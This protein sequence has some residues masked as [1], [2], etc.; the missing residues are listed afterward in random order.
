[1]RNEPNKGWTEDGIVRLWPPTFFT[2]EYIVAWLSLY[3]NVDLVIRPFGFPYESISRFREKN[4]G[5]HLAVNNSTVLRR[6][7]WLHRCYSSVRQ[8]V[9]PVQ[10]V[11]LSQQI[12]AKVQSLPNF[13][14]QTKRVGSTSSQELKQPITASYAQLGAEIWARHL[15]Y[16]P[17]HPTDW[18]NNLVCIGLWRCLHKESRNPPKC[19]MHGL[20]PTHLRWW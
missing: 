9:K 12:F 11:W 4:N 19:I 18:H 6:H 17:P 1:M 2:S 3:Q 10:T 20:I 8:H 5:S 14:S 13:M 16:E 7:V 15:G